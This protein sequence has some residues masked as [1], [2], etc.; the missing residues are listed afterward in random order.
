MKQDVDQFITQ[1]TDPN[2]T[3]VAVQTSGSTGNPRTIFVSK[4]AML[5]SARR[6]NDVLALN[7]GDVALLCLPMQYIAAKMMVVRS[8]ERNLTLH[9]IPPQ[10]NPLK[11]MDASCLGTQTLIAISPHQLS[12]ILSDQHTA[13]FLAQVSHVIVGGGAIPVSVEQRL[14]SFRNK[15]YATYGMTETL[16][17]IALRL[18]TGVQASKKFYALEGVSLSQTTEG[19]LVVHDTF[20]F[21][22]HLTT[23]D[24]VVFSSDG[25]FQII[26]RRDNVV[27]SGGVKLQIEKLEAQLETTPLQKQCLLTYVADDVYG[28]ALTLLYTFSISASEA[29]AHCAQVLHGYELPKHYLY[30]ETLPHTSTGKPARQRAHEL[31]EEILAKSKSA[32]KRS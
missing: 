27:N 10:A 22:K 25:G 18:L 20:T 26:G 14:Q 15:I 5:N 28:Q 17:H 19:C 12:E 6:T 16:S 31:A 2:T 24:I 4:Q 23:N 11:H 1:F 32:I 30:V 8:L 29:K 9:L 3:E 13:Q 21:A 7:P